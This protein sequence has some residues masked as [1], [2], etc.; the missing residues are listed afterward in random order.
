MN[1]FKKMSF[2]IAI[3][4]N[5]K[6]I[7]GITVAVLVLLLVI[8]GK[9][10]SRRVENEIIENI[11]ENYVSEV[12]K[13]QGDNLENYILMQVTVNNF[14]LFVSNKDAAVLELFDTSNNTAD[15]IFDRFDFINED[16][17][18]VIDNV[19]KKDGTYEVK[20]M[21][22]EFEN[23][24]IKDVAAVEEESVEE[25]IF[26]FILDKNGKIIKIVE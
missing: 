5:L 12:E 8:F 23:D 11:K 10:R 13:H 19:L 22:E 2:K 20:V 3:R 15:E 26:T 24:D 17:V 21:F 25:N 18:S 7:M 9:F 1:S 4:K 14:I 16:T 6:L